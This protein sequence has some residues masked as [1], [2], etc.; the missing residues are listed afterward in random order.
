MTM[1][2]SLT[3][4]TLTPTM[5]TPIYKTLLLLQRLRMMIVLAL[6]QVRLPS[7]TL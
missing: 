4:L 3:P 1:M 5:M 6:F 7:I 2:N